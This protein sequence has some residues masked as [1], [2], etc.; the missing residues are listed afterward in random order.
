MLASSII[1][2]IKGIVMSL[3]DVDK[4][5]SKRL[6]PGLNANDSVANRFA[7]GTTQNHNAGEEGSADGLKFLERQ[8]IA[9]QD[10]YN[11]AAFGFYGVSGKFGL[12]VAK[13][14]YDVLSTEDSNLVFNS[15][16]NSFKIVA[17]DTLRI[18][19]TALGSGYGSSVEHSLGSPPIVVASVKSPNDPAGVY[20]MCPYSRWNS[21]TNYIAVDVYSQANT[22]TF[23]VD[24]G[25]AAGSGNIGEWVFKYYILQ[26]TAE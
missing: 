4:N 6:D 20:R 9:K 22:I 5:N 24:L 10:G 18:N 16:Q 26:E 2:I 23:N 19:A 14:G 1:K 7:H 15:E 13:D 11:K 12:K 21:S 3:N 8:I 25:S 17:S